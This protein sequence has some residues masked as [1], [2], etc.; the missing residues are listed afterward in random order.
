M[1]QHN[2]ALSLQRVINQLTEGGW[3]VK[4]AQIGIPHM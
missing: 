3:P 2:P 4:A 1:I